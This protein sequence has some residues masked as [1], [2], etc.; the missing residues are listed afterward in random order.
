M[1]TPNITFV[2]R[3]APREHDYSRISGLPA[4]R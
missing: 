2:T 1:R 4:R 3:R